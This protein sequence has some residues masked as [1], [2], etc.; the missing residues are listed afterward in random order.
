MSLRDLKDNAGQMLMAGFDGTSLPGH[1]HSA[2][3]RGELSGAILFA[4]NVENP[5]QVASLNR[6]I[7]DA[8]IGRMAF[9]AVDQEGGRVQR[10]KAPASVI[11]PMSV[12]GATRDVE[13]IVKMGE[14]VGDEL[15]AMGF[16][17][18]FAPCADVRTNEENQVIGDRAFGDD[19]E[20]V[21]R[22]AGAFMLG[23]TMSGLIPC[24]KHFPGHGD[25]VL[26][27]HFD[28][29]K[30]EHDIERLRQVELAP[31]RAL[32]KANVPMIMTA[33]LLIPALDTHHPATLSP[34]ALTEL[35]RKKLHFG[36]V[37]VSDDLEMKAIADRYP[38]DEV[39][40]L[41]VAAGVDLFLI[42]HS[43]EKWEEAFELLVRMAERSQFEA[44]RIAMSAGR[45]RLLK[46]NYWRPWTKPQDLQSRLDTPEHRALI[47]RVQEAAAR[48][49]ERR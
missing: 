47:E 7:L 6:E 16:N 10:I 3:D 5:E 31:F 40:S 30:I 4:R 14:L 18:N 34:Q 29:P 25:T 17:M 48:R 46:K 22:A 44:E 37:V 38:L 35:L 19:P 12:V 32:I 43:R 41:G 11:P 27:S 9:V 36:G 2:L 1:V 33:H 24:A 15:E 49:Q 13:L 26:D 45:V 21:G 42:C 39:M 20:W 28:L 23:L 8:A